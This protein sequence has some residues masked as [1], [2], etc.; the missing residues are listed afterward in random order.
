PQKGFWFAVNV[1]LIVYGAT[2]PNATVTVDGKPI[3]L[4]PDGTF[5]F[6]YVFPDGHYRMPI[7]A[8]SADGDDRRAVELEFDRQTRDI[9]EVGRVK[10]PEH[11]PQPVTV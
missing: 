10:Q 9:G 6:H 5:S 7:V 4:R 2:E 3:K 1:E 11:L 8:V